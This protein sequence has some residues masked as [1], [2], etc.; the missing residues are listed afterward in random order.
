MLPCA[1]TSTPLLKSLVSSRA[2]L[3]IHL[4]L[5]RTRDGPGHGIQLRSGR[6]LV[7]IWLALGTGG[8]GH[9]PSVNATIYSDDHGSTWHR[10]DI[11]IPNTAA[12]PDPNETTA[13]QLADASVMLNVRTEA[14]ENRR[15]V[16]TSKDGVTHWSRPRLQE[17][18]PD[19]ICF[20]SIVRLSTK[21]D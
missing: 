5:A 8:N 9:H 6:L 18:L 16:V 13:V 19:A 3:R 11:A 4:Y 15:T 20:A 2:N 1:S 14:K 12:F 10:G 7:P 17:D 21:Q